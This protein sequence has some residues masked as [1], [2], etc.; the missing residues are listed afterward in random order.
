[1]SSLME[2]N[3]PAN[4]SSALLMLLDNVMTL[5]RIDKK[6]LN[7]SNGMKTVLREYLRTFPYRLSIHGDIVLVVN[8]EY[9]PLGIRDYSLRVDYDNFHDSWLKLNEISY[10]NADFRHQGFRNGLHGSSYYL[11]NDG[12]PP[13]RN[14]QNLLEYEAR[15]SALLV[16]H[17]VEMVP[18]GKFQWSW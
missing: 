18:K 6:K 14:R 15:L 2:Y 7:Y 1:M 17:G 4:A 13:Y 3:R 8:R 9:K 10:E 12:C 16:K 11:Y 5:R